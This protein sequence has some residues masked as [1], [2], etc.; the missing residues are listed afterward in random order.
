MVSKHHVLG[1]ESPPHWRISAQKSLGF[2]PRHWQKELRR[3]LRK[4]VGHD[5]HLHAVE[6]DNM[7]GICQAQNLVSPLLLFLLLVSVEYYALM[8]AVKQDHYRGAA[9]GGGLDLLHGYGRGG[10]FEMD[11]QRLKLSMAKRESAE[12]PISTRGKYLAN[13]QVSVPQL[14]PFFALSLKLL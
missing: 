9:E 1:D 2:F 6:A 13:Q 11:R 8:T 12:S 5:L 4:V 14:P 3:S 7:W 10:L